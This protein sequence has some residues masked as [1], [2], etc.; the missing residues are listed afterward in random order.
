MDIREI[1][2]SS[3]LTFKTSRSSGKGGQHV[4]KTESRVELFFDVA[5]S[6]ILTEEQK[7][8]LFEIIPNRI[9]QDGV[10]HI[11]ADPDRSQLVNKK[12]VIEKFFQLLEKALKPQKKRKPSK[13]SKAA[14]EKRIQTK[15]KRSEKK[16]LRKF[17]MNISE[18]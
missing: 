4:N 15:K 10:L 2:F 7:Q 14:K 12:T 17:D 8:K 6:Q 16:L 1:D 18:D 11:A 9:S 5:K 3:E 13:P